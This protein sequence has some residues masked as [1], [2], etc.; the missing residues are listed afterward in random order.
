MEYSEES[1]ERAIERTK[2][3]GIFVENENLLL[4]INPLIT[5]EPTRPQLK[6]KTGL[7]KPGV[8]TYESPGIRKKKNRTKHDMSDKHYS[9]K[10]TIIFFTGPRAHGINIPLENAP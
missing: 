2:T 6:K 7:P 1:D 9:T 4:S 8:S 10:E 5:L 3:L